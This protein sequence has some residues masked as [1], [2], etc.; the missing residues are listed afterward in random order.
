MAALPATSSS[1]H[2][3]P[4]GEITSSVNNGITLYQM[5]HR[6]T[7]IKICY[8]P[9]GE[10]EDSVSISFRNKS[11]KSGV[12]HVTEHCVIN[13]S[14]RYPVD[15]A[16]FTTASRVLTSHSSAITMPTFSAFTV[17]TVQPRR[18]LMVL[19]DLLF[20]PLLSPSTVLRERVIAANEVSASARMADY[21]L[22]NAV[23]RRTQTCIPHPVG[24]FPRHVVGVTVNDVI[25]HHKMF[26]R[27][28]NCHITVVSSSPRILSHLDISLRKCRPSGS[29]NVLPNPP[30]HQSLDTQF[31]IE[32]HPSVSSPVMTSAWGFPTNSVTGAD[33][34]TLSGLLSSRFKKK[35]KI[36]SDTDLPLPVFRVTR[37]GG[38]LKDLVSDIRM[39]V[40]AQLNNEREIREAVT[41]NTNLWKNALKTAPH[42]VAIAI[43]KDWANGNNGRISSVGFASCRGVKDGLKWV[44]EQEPTCVIKQVKG[45]VSVPNTTPH[46][47]TDDD[48]GGGGGSVGEHVLPLSSNKE[49]KNYY[50]NISKTTPTIITN[51]LVVPQAAQVVLEI[52]CSREQ[53]HPRAHIDVDVD[54]RV[55][56]KTTSHRLHQSLL[57][58]SQAVMDVTDSVLYQILRSIQTRSSPTLQS[59]HILRCSY[60]ARS[61][62]VM[63]KVLYNAIGPPHIRFV[64]NLLNEFDKRGSLAVKKLLLKALH[65]VYIET[66]T[67]DGG[68]TV[69]SDDGVGVAIRCSSDLDDPNIIIGSSI[70]GGELHT[71]LRERHGVYSTMSNIVG[72]ALW[73]GTAADPS[74]RQST[75]AI[76]SA[77]RSIP[78]LLSAGVSQTSF[79]TIKAAAL[80]EL[81]DNHRLT[82]FIISGIC[83]C[84]PQ[85]VA[86]AWSQF[87]VPHIDTSV[88][89]TSLSQL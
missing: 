9:K 79:R 67:G 85:S 84:T 70:L 41:A 15:N 69:R 43:N 55:S 31:H 13:G 58:S 60:A 18:W 46:K 76:L 22:A 37:S 73:C 42:Q 6:R 52:C 1:S 14:K 7:G 28:N 20:N 89:T 63:Q 59:Q 53:E 5:V 77:V 54:G 71:L 40:K 47:V 39:K 68:D 23:Q 65:G 57:S 21:H 61:L 35:T 29:S 72:D 87:I 45:P 2:L 81:R 66:A 78:K 17:T 16:F 27:P 62:S 30:V 80:K 34:D 11:S 33:V 75:A 88:S 10:G 74:P 12:G 25:G 48:G 36:T 4:Y 51:S 49:V 56:F 24:G 83:D 82:P 32:R 50:N 38:S 64:D 8:V 86:A 3:L 19:V 26:Y 44:S